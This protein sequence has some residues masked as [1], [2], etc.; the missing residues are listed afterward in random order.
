MK[1][2]SLILGIAIAA[3]TFGAVAAPAAEAEGG[4]MTSATETEWFRAGTFELQDEAQAMR[5]ERE[6]FSQYID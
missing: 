4:G 1:V 3:S 5:L 2:T 6:G